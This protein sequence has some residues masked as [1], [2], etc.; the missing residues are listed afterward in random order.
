MPSPYIQKCIENLQRLLV[1]R[2]SGAEEKMRLGFFFSFFFF[3]FAVCNHSKDQHG[4]SCQQFAKAEVA[5]IKWLKSFSPLDDVMPQREEGKRRKGVTPK[6]LQ[7][8]NDYQCT[9]LPIPFPSTAVPQKT[10][11]WDLIQVQ[12][13]FV[14]VCVFM[15]VWGGRLSLCV[16]VCACVCAEA[17]QRQHL[18]QEGSDV[19][20]PLSARRDDR[21]ELLAMD[22]ARRP[23]KINKKKKKEKT[24]PLL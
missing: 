9:L 13:R 18:L 24:G 21:R 15:F 10:K 8:R 7:W 4:F 5:S 11:S 14:C 1:H 20:K 3:F 16:C 6:E 22:G 2:H 23:K 17:E 12:I 19:R